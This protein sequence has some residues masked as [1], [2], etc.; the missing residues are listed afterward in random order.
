MKIF[1]IITIGIISTFDNNNK[2]SSGVVVALST[3]F[4]PYFVIVASAKLHLIFV[5]CRSKH[6]NKVSHLSNPDIYM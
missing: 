4:W 1:T 5:Q 6:V 3:G 2:E